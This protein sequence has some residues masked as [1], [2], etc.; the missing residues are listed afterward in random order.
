M[1]RPQSAS[2][3]RKRQQNGHQAIR[4]AE[5]PDISAQAYLAR[6]AERRIEYVS[7]MPAPISRP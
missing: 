1:V 7:A 6:L 4:S 2:V 3:I 5:S